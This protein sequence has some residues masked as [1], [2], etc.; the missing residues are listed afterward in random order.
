[1]GEFYFTPD[2]ASF[3]I[4]REYPFVRKDAILFPVSPQTKLIKNSQLQSFFLLALFIF[5]VGHFILL[6][7]ASLE[8]DFNGVRVVSP[9]DLLS[10]LQN[11]T[12]TL[13]K[14][15][16]V[17]TA[18]SYSIRELEFF[19]TSE[20]QKNWKLVARKANMYQKE[21]LMHA[22]DMTL[23]L[24]DGTR[25]QSKEGVLYTQTNEM[26][27]FGDVHVYFKDGT[28][29]LCD[30][31]KALMRPVTQISVPENEWIQGQKQNP[32][33]LIEFTS[34]GFFYLDQ[35]P[36]DMKLL[37]DVEFNI[38]TDKKTKV[39]ADT[40]VYRESANYALF[41]MNEDRPLDEQ[42][43]QVTQ[44]DLYIKSRVLHV[45]LT[46]SQKLDNLVATGD[47]YLKD[48]HDPI[49]TSTSTSGK[50]TYYDGKD[51]IYL[52]DFPQVYQ[53]GDTITG[54]TIV[55]NRKKDIIEVK[56]SN[57]IYKR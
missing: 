42:F 47:V 12:E 14:P 5:F 10:F 32:N 18:P 23:Y 51:E 3:G 52:T 54:D 26:E 28:T 21:E 8:E 11:E 48:T 55:F 49:H 50:A 27:F 29:T 9:K 19:A 40:G 44:T 13:A 16:P 6:S 25:V 7:P 30:Y 35:E 45:N 1:M 22:R 33:S 4:L 17:N 38:T 43:V 57:A 41:T 31:A 56:Q 39:R 15:V 53:D 24:G 20:S 34:K 37:H 2:G 46:A 36:K